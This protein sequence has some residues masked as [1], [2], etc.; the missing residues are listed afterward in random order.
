MDQQR[1]TEDKTF[2]PGEKVAISPLLRLLE[3][4]RMSVDRTGNVGVWV[5]SRRGESGVMRVSISRAVWVKT[6]KSCILMAKVRN[7]F[8]SFSCDTT[9]FR[10]ILAMF[11]GSDHDDKIGL[12]RLISSSHCYVFCISRCCNRHMVRRT[13]D[14]CCTC[15]PAYCISQDRLFV[16]RMLYI[17][18]CIIF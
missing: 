13:L 3:P 18:V 2:H 16:R 11:S 17:A 4:P 15:S 7:F 12:S 14:I 10:L 1:V 5:P 6:L 8:F 9:T